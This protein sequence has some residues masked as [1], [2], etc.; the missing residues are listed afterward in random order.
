M[1]S[2]FEILIA[3]FWVYRG[4]FFFLATKSFSLKADLH[5]VVNE[6]FINFLFAFFKRKVNL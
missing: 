5:F 4:L 1:F 6:V 2:F 3:E